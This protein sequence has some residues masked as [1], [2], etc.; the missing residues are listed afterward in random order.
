MIYLNYLYSCIDNINPCLK[1]IEFC[2][3]LYHIKSLFHKAC[4][5]I[6]KYKKNNM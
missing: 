2:M 6:N 1:S 5:T 4:V 3:N